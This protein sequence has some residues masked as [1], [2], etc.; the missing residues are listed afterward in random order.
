MVQHLQL[1]CNKCSTRRV[2]NGSS[3]ACWG[4]SLKAR[5][6]GRDAGLAILS[7]RRFMRADAEVGLPVE[8]PAKIQL[9]AKSLNPHNLHHAPNKTLKTSHH[10]SATRE[11]L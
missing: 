1:P 6:H 11:R 10:T 4:W 9:A 8:S 7:E 5:V 3:H 2:L